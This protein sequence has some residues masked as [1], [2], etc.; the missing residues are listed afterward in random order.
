[1]GIMLSVEFKCLGRVGKVV[2]SGRWCGLT[3]GLS[4]DF[5]ESFYVLKC[6]VVDETFEK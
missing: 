3:G 5:C 1:M 2:R 4:I 6:H